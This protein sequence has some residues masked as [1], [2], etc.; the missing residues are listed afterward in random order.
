MKEL[1]INIFSCN[2]HRLPFCFRNIDELMKVTD[3]SRVKLLVL[4]NDNLLPSWTTKLQEISSKLQCEV[5]GC[6]PDYM[7]RTRISMDTKCKYSSRLD[8]DILLSSYVWQFAL[9][10]IHIL[11]D[12]RVGMIS[13][14]LTT[15]TFSCEFFIDDFMS[16]TDQRN[17]R[18]L[19]KHDNIIRNLW[20]TD[21]GP[22]VDFVNDALIWDPD[23]YFDVV[24]S[25]GIVFKGV[26]PI[27]FSDAANLFMCDRVATNIDKF[28]TKQD[29]RFEL[30][31]NRHDTHMAFMFRTDIW[32]E[33]LK[34]QHDGFD[35]IPLNEYYKRNDLEVG[36]IRNGFG[37]H[38]AHGQ[39]DSQSR[40]EDTYIKTLNNYDSLCR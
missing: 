15:S 2:E 6:S 28:F 23:M 18:Q 10:N 16:P 35:E 31:K 13:P 34:I 8:D 22:I 24:N 12:P 29:Y 21:Y 40:I 5:I 14:I 1:Q 39:I 3:L 27:R 7:S 19:F 32:S 33:A 9:D 37:I 38:M 4:T 25:L 30:V 26:H 11:D 20:G 17:I 36:Y